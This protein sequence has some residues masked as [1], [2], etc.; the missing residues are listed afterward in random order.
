MVD[1]ETYIL[2]LSVCPT[3]FGENRRLTES[4]APFKVTTFDTKPIRNFGRLRGTS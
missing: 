3:I 4:I 2:G 1:F